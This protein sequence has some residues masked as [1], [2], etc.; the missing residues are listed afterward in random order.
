MSRTSHAVVSVVLLA[1]L[2]GAPAAAVL[3]A[4]WCA[5][6]STPAAVA[7]DCHGTAGGTGTVG[8]PGDTDCADHGLAVT[9]VAESLIATRVGEV[10]PLATDWVGAG[11]PAAPAG[12]PSGFPPG[13]THAPP[14]RP[15]P[16]RLALRI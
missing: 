1:V 11:L 12:L 4:E 2:S 5:G 14:A 3:C 7:L 13:A 8:V 9:R 16:S 15:A 6:H 10:H